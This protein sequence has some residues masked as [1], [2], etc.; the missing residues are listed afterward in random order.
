MT[1]PQFQYWATAMALEVYTLIFVQSL[2]EADFAMYLDA[3]TELMPWFF[4]L[5]H[6]N[7]ARW[8]PVHLKDMAELAKKHPGIYREFDGG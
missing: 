7:Y 2:R 6:T 5:G 3:L 8:I 4:A 1:S